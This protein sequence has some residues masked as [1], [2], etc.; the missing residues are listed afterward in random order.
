MNRSDRAC[1]APQPLYPFQSPRLDFPAP[2]KLIVLGATGSIGRQ[3]LDLVRAH[4]DRLQVVA[5]SC[6]SRVAD[7]QDLL[8]GL[9]QAQPGAPPPLVAVADPQ[10]HR[11]A[12]GR[13]E[14]AGRLLPPGPQGLVAAVEEAEDAHCLVNAL[15]GAAGLAP[16]LAGARRGLRIALA[17]KES[18]VVGGELVGQAARAF[19]A[20]ILPVDSE[21]TAIAQCLA[22]RSPQEV[23]RLILT[24]S[25]GPFRTTPAAQLSRVTLDQVLAHPTW[26]MGPKITVDSATLMNKGLEIIEAHHLFG[27][28]Y[29]RIDVVVHPGSIVHSLV[30]FVDGALLAQLGTPDMRIPLQYAISGERHWPLP[31][32]SLDLLSVGPLCF[33]APDL[34]RFPCLRLARQAGLAGGTA[35]IVLNAAN[36]VAVAAVLAGHAHYV[37]ISGIIQECLAAAGTAPVPDLETALAVDRR[38]RQAAQALL[39]ARNR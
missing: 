17:N 11:A 13:L 19:G 36:E 33:E 31:A 3:T 2:L 1:P 5:V 29:D 22:G 6:Q 21:H 28:P 35:P 38:T 8:A 25:G 4:P 24:A 39:A 27:L 15:V 23:R 16:T 14:P 30:E 18:L 26:A 10:A 20:E 32:G 34:E 37:D 9:R 7:L 12:A